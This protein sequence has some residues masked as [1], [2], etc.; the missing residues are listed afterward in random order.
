MSFA[1]NRERAEVT[2]ARGNGIKL[3][4]SFAVNNERKVRFEEM[5][6]RLQSLAERDVFLSDAP[7]LRA[8]A[9]ARTNLNLPITLFPRK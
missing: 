2:K 7:L 6:S 9:R 3:Q 4:N 1:A 5:Y 8:R